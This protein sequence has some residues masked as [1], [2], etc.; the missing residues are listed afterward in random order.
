MHT[1]DET[2]Y[3]LAATVVEKLSAANKT[4]SFAESCTG[5]LVA[6]KLVDVPSASSVFNASVVTYANEAKVDY[7]GVL[8]S[9]IEE[10]GVVSEPVAG[11]MAAGVAKRNHAQVGVG[12]SG[13]AGPTGGS[14][15][16]PVGMV[17]FGFSFDGDIWTATQYFGD[18]G[19]NEVRRKSVEFVYRVL[20]EKLYE[21]GG[22]YYR[23]V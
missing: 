2:I 17:C 23:K 9:T 1:S 14:S 22:C 20:A 7:L 3:D 18:I 19:R 11:Q 16:K 13:I 12:V 15:E 8:E 6:A 4:I 5:G 10:F 21:Q